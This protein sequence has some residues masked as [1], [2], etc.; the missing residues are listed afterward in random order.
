LTTVGWHRVCIGQCTTLDGFH[1]LELEGAAMNVGDMAP[2]F[3]LPGTT[4][5]GLDLTELR[6][7]GRAALFFYPA[8]RTAG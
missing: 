2:T 4:G 3:S 7:K 5:P 6:G 8:D 1:E